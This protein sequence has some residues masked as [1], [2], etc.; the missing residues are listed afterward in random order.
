MSPLCIIVVPKGEWHEKEAESMHQKI[1]AENFPNLRRH[2]DI[3]IY[4]V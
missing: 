4:E 2:M 1:M 3:H